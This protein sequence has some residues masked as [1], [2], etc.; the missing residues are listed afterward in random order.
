MNAIRKISIIGAGN[1]ATHLGKSLKNK[2]CIIHQVFSRTIENSALLAD[3]LEAESITNISELD[4]NIDLLIV[5]IK[6]DV[7]LDVLKQIDVKNVTIAHTSGSVPMNVFEAA[8]F[9]TFGIFYPL[10][11]FSKDKAVDITAVP[12]CIEGSNESTAKAL[13]DLASTISNQ[14]SYIDSEQRKVLHVAAVFACNFSNYM[15]QISDQILE[16]NGMSLDLLKPL[17]KETANKIQ[18]NSPASMQTGPAIRKDQEVI[19]K[20]LDFLK[21]HKDYAN[22]YELL[23]KHISG[24]K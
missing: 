20:H 5:A 22:I 21:A 12:F 13:H 3:E 8:G 23:T 2:G 4:P 6:D 1:V 15:Y 24:D 9:D 7:I 14:V 19:T 17:I 16:D 10:Q 18:N 11:T